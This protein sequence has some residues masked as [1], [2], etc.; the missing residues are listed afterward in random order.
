MC[1]FSLYCRIPKP[2]F[3]IPYQRNVQNINNN[4]PNFHTKDSV[5]KMPEFIAPGAWFP[6]ESAENLDVGS[7]RL[8][9]YSMSK[10]DFFYLNVKTLKDGTKV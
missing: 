8:A 9:S 2:R 1:R 7:N 5:L 4:S 3:V 10:N 6:L